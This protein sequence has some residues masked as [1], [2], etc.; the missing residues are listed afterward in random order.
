MNTTVFQLLGLMN[1][2]NVHRITQQLSQNIV[3]MTA[4]VTLNPDVTI[5]ENNGVNSELALDTYSCR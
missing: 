2:A 4:Y 1:L 3:P 5:V